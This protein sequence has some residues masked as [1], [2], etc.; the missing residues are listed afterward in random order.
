MSEM[1]FLV[2]FKGFELDCSV[3]IVIVKEFN[4]GVMFLG[5][6]Y[7]LKNQSNGQSTKEAKEV[8]AYCRCIS[9]SWN[10]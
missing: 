3:L 5:Q 9:Y 1:K 2:E 6:A 10:R 4:V 7:R 8:V